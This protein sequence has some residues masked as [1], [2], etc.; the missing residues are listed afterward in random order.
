MKVFVY[1]F[2]AVDLDT[3]RWHLGNNEY[4]DV[5]RQYQDILALNAD[6]VIVNL[7]KCDKSILDIIR[8][9]ENETKDVEEREYLYLSKEVLNEWNVEMHSSERID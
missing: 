4:I 2:S 3:I 9:Y 1:G 7:E 5:T 8:S 6:I